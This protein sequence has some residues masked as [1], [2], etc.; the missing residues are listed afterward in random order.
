MVYVKVYVDH[1]N[2][3]Q[4]LIILVK[5]NKQKKKLMLQ[6]TAEAAEDEDASSEDGDIE[7]VG[8]HN[9]GSSSSYQF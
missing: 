3:W 4:P 1:A 7:V 9:Q 8:K 6:N 2:M 5:V